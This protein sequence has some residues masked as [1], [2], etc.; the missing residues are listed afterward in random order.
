MRGG[1]QRGNEE[2]R[3]AIAAK[4][5]LNLRRVMDEPYARRLGDG[6]AATAATMT[7]AAAVRRLIVV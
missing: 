2:L 3:L 5:S 6:A 1:L 7:W 4:E